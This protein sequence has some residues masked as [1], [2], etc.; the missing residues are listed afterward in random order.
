MII[1][2]QIALTA[3]FI[4]GSP[5]VNTGNHIEAQEILSRAVYKYAEYDAY[6]AH[7]YREFKDL[8]KLRKNAVVIIDKTRYHVD[9]MFIVHQREIGYIASG[10]TLFTCVDDKDDRLIVKLR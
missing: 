1:I 4:V 3:A 5:W 2:P 7:D 9:R 6:G 8:H 10:T